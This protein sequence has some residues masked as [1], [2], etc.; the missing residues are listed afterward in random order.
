MGNCDRVGYQSFYVYYVFGV[1]FWIIEVC[2]IVGYI[3]IE[4]WVDL[5]KDDSNVVG[6]VFI[7]VGICI[8]DNYFGV[9]VMNCEMFVCVV[10]CKQVVIGCIIKNG[11]IDDGVFCSN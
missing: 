10:C 9:R 3:C 7:C 5:I 4:V 2:Y 6:Y 1:V 11:V 8:F